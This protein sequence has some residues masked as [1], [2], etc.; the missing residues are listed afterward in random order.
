M[1]Q[2]FLIFALICLGLIQ[3]INA[4][5]TPAADLKVGDELIIGPPV[6]NNYKYIAVPRKNIIIKKG[7]IAN[8]SS[9]KDNKVTI[10]KITYSKANKAVV[11]LKKADGNKFFNAC[12]SLKA[13]LNA[14][15]TYGE[16][17]INTATANMGK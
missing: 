1:K 5:E 14:A 12:R 13:N 11:V 3:G 4:Q 2:S 10:S 6:A 9:I 16:L 17:K 7:G 15:L 8:L